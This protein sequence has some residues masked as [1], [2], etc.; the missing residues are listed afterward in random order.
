LFFANRSGLEGNEY[1]LTRHFIAAL[2]QQEEPV[3]KYVL[4]LY[5]IEDKE[6]KLYAVDTLF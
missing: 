2:Y 3:T 4:S 6:G 5:C 1:L